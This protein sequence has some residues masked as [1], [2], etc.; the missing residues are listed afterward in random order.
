[1]TYEEIEQLY[2]EDFKRRQEDKFN[3]RYPRGESY[4]D[5]LSRLD[6]LVME[7]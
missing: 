3:Y 4:L 2:P 6:P 1:M 5:I 7:M